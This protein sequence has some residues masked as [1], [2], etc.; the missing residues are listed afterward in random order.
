M[1]ACNWL[2]VCVKLVVDADF[3]GAFFVAKY[4][5]PT[6]TNKKKGRFLGHYALPNGGECSPPTMVNFSTI[7]Q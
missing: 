1:V 4:N 2:A 6:F 5:T 7:S 3:C